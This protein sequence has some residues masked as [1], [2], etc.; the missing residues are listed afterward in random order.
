M[1]DFVHIEHSIFIKEGKNVLFK[2][3][4]PLSANELY[5]LHNY[6]D[7]SLA[8]GWIQHSKSS[9]DISILFVSKKD[10]GLHLYINYWGLN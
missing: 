2:S 1:S 5:V 8:K 10:D 6:L 9:A 4:Y 3:I 7:L